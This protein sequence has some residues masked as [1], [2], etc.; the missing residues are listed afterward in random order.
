LEPLHFK[1][2]S[3]LTGTSSRG[4]PLTLELDNIGFGPALVGY[5]FFSYWLSRLFFSN[6]VQVRLWP[7]K[8]NY[9]PI[10]LSILFGNNHWLCIRVG[11]SI[12][13]LTITNQLVNCTPIIGFFQKKICCLAFIIKMFSVL[14]LITTSFG[15]II[16]FLKFQYQSI[17]LLPFT[18]L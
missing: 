15:Y 13:Q 5:W 10:R 9:V 16:K 17:E 8:K 12:T 18:Q 7:S 11:F 6:W 14:G 2:P 4:F 3:N 1:V